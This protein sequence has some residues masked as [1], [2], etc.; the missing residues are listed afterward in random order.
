MSYSAAVVSGLLIVA[1]VI[2]LL[3]PDY[4]KKK[5]FESRKNIRMLGVV[6]FCIAILFA[7]TDMRG[8]AFYDLLESFYKV[9]QK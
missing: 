6:V 1:S 9:F 7:I 5:F 3:F 4:S 8:I 2:L